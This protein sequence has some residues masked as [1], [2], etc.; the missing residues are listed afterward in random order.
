MILIEPNGIVRWERFSGLEGNEF[1]K[2]VLK[3]LLEKYGE[4]TSS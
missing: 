4:E 1:T 2:D 3:T